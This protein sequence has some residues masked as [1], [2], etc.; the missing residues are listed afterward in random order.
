MVDGLAI[1][2]GRGALPRLIAEECARSGRPYRVVVFDGVELDWLDGHP[3]L[4][5]AF[6]RPGRLFAAMIL[7]QEEA[8]AKG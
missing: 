2:A 8:G 3:V 4:R 5:A 1:V 6:E 7:T